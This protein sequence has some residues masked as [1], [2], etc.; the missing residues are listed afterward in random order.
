VVPTNKPLVRTNH[1]D[2]IYKTEKEKFKAI[3]DEIEELHR[4]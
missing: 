3:C 1:P 4:V 2:I